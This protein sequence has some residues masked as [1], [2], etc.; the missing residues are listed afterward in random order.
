MN[1]Y[2]LAAI[3]LGMIGSSA[4][5][6]TPISGATPP[7]SP[8]SPQSPPQPIY[9]PPPSPGVIRVPSGQPMVGYYKM[10]ALLVGADGFYPYDTGEY[11]LAGLQGNARSFGTFVITLPSPADA[12]PHN[13]PAPYKSLRGLCQ[14][15]GSCPS[16]PFTSCR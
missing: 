4:V 1:R 5:A 15:Y 8:P 14:K 13:T 16:G 9:P 12:D 10:D 7:W 6:Q 2:A 11:N 3:F